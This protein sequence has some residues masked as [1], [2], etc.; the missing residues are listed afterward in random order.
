MWW[1]W[2]EQNEFYSAALIPSSYGE[3]SRVSLSS[4][5]VGDY[6]TVPNMVRIFRSGLQI[7]NMQTALFDKN[8]IE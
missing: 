7:R 3:S 2:T 8:K 6:L 1:T 4:S 5:I